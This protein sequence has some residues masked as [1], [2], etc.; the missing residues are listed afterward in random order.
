MTDFECIKSEKDAYGDVM[1]CCYEY[2]HSWISNFSD[3]R[4][5]KEQMIK[6]LEECLDFVKG[7]K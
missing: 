4:L 3:C 7:C 2:G 1:Y 5:K 6:F